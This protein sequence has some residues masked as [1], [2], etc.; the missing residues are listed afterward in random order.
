MCVWLR[1]YLVELAHGVPGMLYAY[2][3]VRERLYLYVVPWSGN[4]E[5][6]CNQT[7]P[8]NKTRPPQKPGRDQHFANEP[9]DEERT[10]WGI[11]IQEVLAGPA[12][13]VK[14]AQTF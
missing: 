7:F 12:S 8:S 4:I 9:E 1:Q 11:V 3:T 5:I 6:L 13:V 2:A 14:V 10:C